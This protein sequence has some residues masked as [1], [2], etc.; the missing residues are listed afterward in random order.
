[1][2]KG[3]DTTE[4]PVTADGPATSIRHTVLLG[5]LCGLG[6]A[7]IWGLTFVATKVAMNAGL[8]AFETLF[9]RFLIA[10]LAL[11]AIRP[12]LPRWNGWR[13]EWPFVAC[14]ACGVSFYYLL[15]Y[16]SLLYTSASF[17]SIICALGPLFVSG[18]LWLVYRQRPRRLFFAGFAVCALGTILVV[19]AGG[20]GL[21]VTVPGTLLALAGNVLWA[22][23]CVILRR[24]DEGGTAD[25]IMSIRRIFFWGLITLA[26]C[27][28][29]FGFD[30]SEVN[31]LAPELISSLLILG[32]LASCAAYILYSL[33]TRF[34]GES[35]T[36]VYLYFPPVVASISAY[37][38][39]GESIAL[40]G[41]VGIV[42][43]IAGLIISQKG[44]A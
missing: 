34:I 16:N 9:L 19:T 14:G 24:T 33:G 36:S 13:A 40:A 42:T 27:A 11:W 8:S 20:V 44:T 7:L 41:I 15:E 31:L 32:L 38:L 43:I 21:A 39:L 10:Y 1:V 12:R 26:P 17:V 28:F 37:F 25:T 22:S 3:S 30:I 6:T 35:A 23:Y 4:G 2:D 5:H 18:A 29:F